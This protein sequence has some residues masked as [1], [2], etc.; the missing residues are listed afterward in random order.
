MPQPPRSQTLK[1][2]KTFRVFHFLLETSLITDEGY[3]NVTATVNPSATTHFTL[4][5]EG[6]VHP[7]AGSGTVFA[8]PDDIA[9]QA[10]YLPLAVR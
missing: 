2:L 10:L 3:Y 4:D 7:Q 5:N 9:Y 6:E 1:V 8:V